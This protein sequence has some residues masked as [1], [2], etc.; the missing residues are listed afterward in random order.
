MLYPFKESYIEKQDV[1]LTFN[2]EQFNLLIDVEEL[3]CP[4][5]MS[6]SYNRWITRIT[7]QLLKILQGFCKSILPIAENKVNI[8]YIFQ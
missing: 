7:K 2:I 3:W 1:E 4:I 5:D 6:I 8:Y